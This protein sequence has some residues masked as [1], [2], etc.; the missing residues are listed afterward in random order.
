MILH[1]SNS[2][3]P[4]DKTIFSNIGIT[5]IYINDGELE[6]DA[7][8]PSLINRFHNCNFLFNWTHS[9]TN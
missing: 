9:G 3:V 4:L 7:V 1:N 6:I 5:Q 8:R 2:K